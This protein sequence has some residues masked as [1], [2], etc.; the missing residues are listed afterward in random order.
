MFLEQNKRE[1]FNSVGAGGHSEGA[2]CSSQDISFVC[3]VRLHCEFDHNTFITCMTALNQQVFPTLRM[4]TGQSSW[5]IQSAGLLMSPWASHRL[6]FILA[7]FS[8][9]LASRALT[10]HHEGFRNTDLTALLHTGWRIHTVCP[11][12]K[13][14]R[15]LI[16]CL[17][18]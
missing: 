16:H 12:H 9:A 13:S 2:R 6:L 17:L 11:V 4:P 5:R 1:L 8:S 14:I 10:Q 7:A 15:C 18:R 3:I